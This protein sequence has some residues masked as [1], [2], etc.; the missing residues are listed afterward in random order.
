M[1]VDCANGT[2][3]FHKKGIAD[4][5]EQDKKVDLKFINTDYTKFETLNEKCGAEHVHKDRILPVNYPETEEE[6]L[7]IK[8]V[9]FDGDV[10]RIIYL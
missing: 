9:S 7:Y 6:E 5:F 3:A 4:I 8:N 2:A 1:L 10:D